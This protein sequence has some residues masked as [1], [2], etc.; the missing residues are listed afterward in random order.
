MKMYVHEN[1][2]MFYFFCIAFTNLSFGHVNIVRMGQG[3]SLT[4]LIL[5]LDLSPL[6]HNFHVHSMVSMSRD[7]QDQVVHW[8]LRV[9]VLLR[10]L[11]Y[12]RI[13]EV[14]RR[15]AHLPKAWSI[16]HSVT[17]STAHDPKNRWRI[18]WQMYLG[19]NTANM[20]FEHQSGMAGEKKLYTPYARLSSEVPYLKLN[21][22]ILDSIVNTDECSF[23][24]ETHLNGLYIKTDCWVVLREPQTPQSLW[25]THS[26]S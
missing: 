6:L 17:S 10:R 18:W 22:F 15:W 4:S 13:Q 12:C 11:A 7:L 14:A 25:H 23:F 9:S 20:A 26:E 3:I 1:D 16:V 19:N 8:Y 24:F 21:V 2:H 5:P